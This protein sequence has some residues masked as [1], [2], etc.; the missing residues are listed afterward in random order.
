MQKTMTIRGT[1]QP[2]RQLGRRLG[3]PTA[4]LP[5]TDR[6]GVDGCRAAGVWVARITIEKRGERYW[7]LVNVGRRPTVEPDAEN[8]GGLC[9]AEAWLFDF[10]GD[11]YGCELRIELL[12][13]L[14]PERKFSSVEALREA[15]EQDKIQAVDIIKN[16]DEYTL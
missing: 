5:L 2:G 14:R 9:T 1:V 8:G 12:H 16:D 10:D 11:L 4:N 13:F 7:G 15:M 3:F 6:D